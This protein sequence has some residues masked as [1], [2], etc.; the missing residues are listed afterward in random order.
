MPGVS[1]LD[2]VGIL[3]SSATA[4]HKGRMGRETSFRPARQSEEKALVGTIDKERRHR[5]CS[6][7]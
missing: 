4:R 7:I 5:A 1:S 3:L 2:I 6:R